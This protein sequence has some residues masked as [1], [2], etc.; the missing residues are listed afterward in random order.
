MKKIL[1]AI[2][3]M[4]FIIGPS[5]AFADTATGGQ[6]PEI[7]SVKLPNA[8]GEGTTI[9]SL[10]EK[11]TSLLTVAVS[12]LASFMIIIGAF[13]IMTA[14][15]D[16]GKFAKGKQIITYAVIGFIVFLLANLIVNVISELIGVTARLGPI[17]KDIRQIA[18]NIFFI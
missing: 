3:L 12:A 6:T 4:S 17:M 2:C 15:G 14:A 18:N 10:F 1:F 13:Q 16:P 11:F 7:P 8:F 5:L 9:G